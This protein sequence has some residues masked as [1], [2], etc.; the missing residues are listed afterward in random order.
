M[1]REHPDFSWSLKVRL[2]GLKTKYFLHKYEFFHKKLQCCGSGLDPVN[3][4]PGS[5]YGYTSRIN[6][7]I[8]LIF[9][10]QNPES[11]SGFTSNA[12]SK[13]NESGSATLKK[14]RLDP[15]H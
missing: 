8:F 3:G 7:C 9:G 11:G 4:V 14:L 15:H 12:G 2:W 6:S 5:G 13:F 10:H 1:R